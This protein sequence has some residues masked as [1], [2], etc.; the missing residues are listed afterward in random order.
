MNA[1]TILPGHRL[2]A[3]AAASWLRMAEDGMPT[4]GVRSSLRT[5][6]EQRALFLA[7]YRPARTPTEVGPY[8]DAR[9]YLG[10]RYVRI[11]GEGSV[12]V[13]GSPQANHED[14]LA[15][16]LFGDTLAWVREHGH[17]YGW[18]KDLVSGEAWHLEYIE[19]RDTHRNRNEEDPDML[20]IRRTVGS[21]HNYR[22]VTGDRTV[23]LSQAAAS[24][25][26]DAGVKVVPLPS[27][28]YLRIYK[29]LKSE[30]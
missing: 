4:S 24:D 30:K 7:R 20:I 21:T 8:R 17:R 26:K 14:G 6:D 25:L 2:A 10:V 27:A 28:D 18:I 16:D 29:T 1:V 12:A 5:R 19:T 15:L 13:P 9:K 23:Q 22:L 11:S 3:P